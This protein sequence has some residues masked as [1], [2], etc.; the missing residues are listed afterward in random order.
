MRN[1]YV[2]VAVML[3]AI[4]LLSVSFTG[5]YVK[6]NAKDA[7]GSKEQVTIV[8]SFY[9]MYVAVSNLVDGID[10]IRVRN[11]SEPQTGCL[12][13]FQLTP[14]DMKLLS[15]AD[16]FVVNGGGIENFISDVAKTYPTLQIVQ[17]CEEISLLES[18]GHVHEGVHD[19]EDEYQDEDVH[20]SHE[21]EFEDMHESHEQE[22]V[23]YHEEGHE[24]EHVHEEE[25]L[26]EEEHVYEEEHVHEEEEEHDHD[27]V[28]EELHE[29][30]DGHD[31]D[32]GDEN[33][34][35]WMSVASY[36]EQM[37]HIA[38]RLADILP[39]YRE[40]ITEN[41]SLYDDK[42]AELQ[43]E[44]KE[45]CALVK[46]REVI[47]FHE[48]YA[49]VAKDYGLEVAMVMDLDEERQVSAGEVAEVLEEIKEH[50]V[51]LILA[52]ERYGKEM[53]DT[54]QKE[55]DVDVIY[56]DTLNRGNYEKD[57]YLVGM[58]SNIDLLRQVFIK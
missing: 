56:L 16:V 25:G 27:V 31:H 20:E 34:H 43:A 18:E 50:G 26:H 29:E 4:L 46:G 21:Y 55:V 57:S 52:E 32:H 36:R 9:P 30:E 54:I 2:F 41:A 3:C 24:E 58:Q 42:L 8:T 47:L 40:S 6:Q 28:H 33:A 48:A 1:K 53:G 35:A 7:V 12:H 45:L 38:E 51:S 10:E 49:Y 39:Q 44:Q 17:A 15:N 22:E 13:D 23:H 14:E 11:L 37:T 5:L 19:H